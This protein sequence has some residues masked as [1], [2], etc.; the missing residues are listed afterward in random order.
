MPTANPVPMAPAGPRTDT[1]PEFSG[2]WLPLITPFSGD[3][4]AVDHA[5][6]KRLL[7]HYRPSGI[8]GYVVC[9]STGEAAALGKEEQWAVL[10]TVL[11]H[12][13]GLPVVMGFSG[14]HQAD[15]IAFVHKACT[16]PIAGLLVAAPHYIRPS[17]EGLLCWFERIADA[18]SKPIIVYDIPYRTG[19]E[20]ALKTLQCLS[21]H[22]NICAIKDCGGDAAKTQQLIADG[23]LQVLAGEDLQIFGSVAA[24]ASGAISASAHLCTAQFAEVIRLIQGGQLA[25]ARTHWQALV[26]VVRALFAEPNPAGVKSALTQAGMIEDRLRE[27]MQK[28]RQAFDMRLLAKAEKS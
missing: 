10:D 19:V 7:A 5:A 21:Q 1:G 8:A 16:L 17:Q 15:A 25:A 3:A 6:L 2:L 12:A 27:P 13:D 23:K 18:A 26:P 11:E 4:H 28:A 24:G 20:I 9:G 14:Y 22:P